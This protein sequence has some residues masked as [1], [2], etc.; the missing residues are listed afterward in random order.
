MGMNRPKGKGSFE[1]LLYQDIIR[2]SLQKEG[3]EAQIEGKI[4]AGGKL[5]DV[6]AFSKEKGF[7]AYEV[8]LHF[9]NLISNITED[10]QAG[11]SRVV[12]VTRDKKEIEKAKKMAEADP[13]LIKYLGRVSFETIDHFFG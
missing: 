11:V 6:L 5:I 8:T 3:I 4:K 12:I 9:D 2:Q 7:L 10:L 1:H 13:R